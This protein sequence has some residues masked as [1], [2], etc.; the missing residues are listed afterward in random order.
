[1]IASVCIFILWRNFGFGMF[2]QVFNETEL[3]LLTAFEVLLK[4]LPDLVLD[5]PD[6]AT[7]LGNFIARAVADDCLPPKFVQVCKEKVDCDHAR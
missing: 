6:A 1:M 2:F 5:T 4:N 7:V 3:F